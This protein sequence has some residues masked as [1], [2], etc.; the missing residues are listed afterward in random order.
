[1]FSFWKQPKDDASPPE[2]S[3]D[4]LKQMTRLQ[5]EDQQD[6]VVDESSLQIWHPESNTDLDQED[7]IERLYQQALDKL[8]TVEQEMELNSDAKLNESAITEDVEQPDCNEVEDS[9]Q[10]FVLNGDLKNC[11]GQNQGRVTPEQIL[12]AVLFVGGASLTSKKLRYLLQ[13]EFNN[14]FIEATIAN[15]NK[16]YRGENRPYEILFGEGGYRMM[17]RQE[18]ERVCIRTFGMGPKEVKLSQDALEM[19]AVVAYKQPITK[20]EIESLGKQKPHG[21]LRQLLRRE[22]ISIERDDKNPKEVKYHTTERFLQLFGLKNISELPTA[23]DL[24][25]K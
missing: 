7:E 16:R 18:Y 4:D 25:F 21:T 12:E 24:E 19:L 22:I 23:E 13:D 1:M 3:K 6:D 9:N 15:L 17:L 14:D 2:L 5:T 8:E 11:P 10:P 20:Q